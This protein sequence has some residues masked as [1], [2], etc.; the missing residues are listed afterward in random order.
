M[1]DGVAAKRRP[2]YLARA[3]F[4]SEVIERP[5]LGTFAVDRQL[6]VYV[7]PEIVGD[8]KRWTER[9]AAAVLVHELWH[10]LKDHPKRIAPRVEVAAD[11]AAEAQRCNIAADLEIN[12]GMR[13]SGADL[14]PDLVFPEDYG[15]PAHLSL[16]GYLELLAQRDQPQ[17]TKQ[18]EG[19]KSKNGKDKG[20]KGRGK[21]KGQQGQGAEKAPQGAPGEQDGIPSPEGK[22]PGKGPSDELPKGKT[23]PDCG[24]GAHGQPRPWEEPSDEGQPARLSDAARD[25]LRRQVSQDIEAAAARDPGSV[26]GFARRWAAEQLDPPRV[27]WE[28]ELQAAIAQS[29]TAR[30]GAG[31]YSWLLPSRRGDFCGVLQPRLV[32]PQPEVVVA[33]DTSGS[34]TPALLSAALSEVEG[35]IRSLGQHRIQAVAGDMGAESA[36]V[37]S[38]AHDIALTGGGGTDMGALARAASELVPEARTMVILTD[39]YT[40][41]PAEPLEGADLVVAVLAGSRFEA[42]RIAALVPEWAKAIPVELSS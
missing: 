35:I 32:R 23:Q 6:R 40:P 10:V 7:D 5:G 24:S 12:G 22:G 17:E 18:G 28:Q 11:H 27:P 1:M 3:L 33:I 8:G 26:P 29:V 37:V 4:A 2:V 30:S 38:S 9:Q 31:D 16:E 13:G 14:P 15:F 41:W 34:M 39:G 19:G 42:E 20:S 25:M 36:Q 21:G